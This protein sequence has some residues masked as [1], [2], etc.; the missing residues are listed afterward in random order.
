MREK[1]AHGLLQVAKGRPPVLADGEVLRGVPVQVLHPLPRHPLVIFRNRL[2]DIDDPGDARSGIL[3]PS[4][5]QLL[6]VEVRLVPVCRAHLERGLQVDFAVVE[7]V[8]LY[9]HSSGHFVGVS[10]LGHLLVV[11]LPVPGKSIVVDG[12]ARLQQEGVEHGRLAGAVR[13]DEHDEPRRCRH[14]GDGEFSEP[15]V[16]L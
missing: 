13:T 12:R 8:E 9:P 16:V 10:G 5:L 3:R 4:G 15:L 7:A 1:A 14:V 6:N 2:V 11:M